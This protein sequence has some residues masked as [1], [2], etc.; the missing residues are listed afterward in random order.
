M[1]NGRTNLF[2]SFLPVLYLLYITPWHWQ[3]HLFR[4][5]RT[6]QLCSFDTSC[7]TNGQWCNFIVIC[8][9]RES[10]RY[11]YIRNHCV[12]VIYWLMDLF[13]FLS[14]VFLDQV[15]YFY[16]DGLYT[17]CVL[18]RVIAWLTLESHVP[19]FWHS[20][21]FISLVL[22]EP[23]KVKN[24]CLL[25]VYWLPGKCQINMLNIHILGR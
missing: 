25:N 3:S 10:R 15:G 21:I 24:T 20:E 4:R 23:K 18:K 17:S 14:I 8:P 19:I 2:R 22:R 12:S 9:I 13:S 6:L 7:R 1:F 5:S 16:N 11:H